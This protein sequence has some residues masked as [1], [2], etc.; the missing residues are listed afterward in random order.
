M[1][2]IIV[3]LIALGFTATTALAQTSSSSGTGTSS[4]GTTSPG[5]SIGR[6]APALGS[7][8]S[9]PATPNRSNTDIFPPSR[10]LPSTQGATGTQTPAGGSTLSSPGTGAA[11][12]TTG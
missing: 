8:P 11:T 2:T 9:G 7:T 3:G 10:L 6:G 12:T 5:T 4:T 1:R